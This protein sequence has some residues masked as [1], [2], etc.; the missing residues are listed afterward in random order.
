MNIHSIKRPKK[1]LKLEDY[2]MVLYELRKR[3][4]VHGYMQ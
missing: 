2:C 4:E 3:Q 1:P